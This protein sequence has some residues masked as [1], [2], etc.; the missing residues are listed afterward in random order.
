MLQN[1]LALSFCSQSRPVNIRHD[2]SASL[3][4]EKETVAPG[5]EW[6]SLGQRTGRT[7]LLFQE[8]CVIWVLN[9]SDWAD[10]LNMV[11]KPFD[12]TD[13]NHLKTLAE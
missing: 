6:S 1:V 9:G 10:G 2:W 8:G 12:C 5:R 3:G 13:K 7:L 11:D 4:P